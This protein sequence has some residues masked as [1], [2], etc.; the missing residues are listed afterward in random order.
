MFVFSS[1]IKLCSVI[2]FPLWLSQV[3]WSSST[4]AS[5]SN[6]E[7][8]SSPTHNCCFNV[9]WY[10][11]RCLNLNHFLLIMMLKS[12]DSFANISSLLNSNFLISHHPLE[13][14]SM[15]GKTSKVIMLSLKIINFKLTLFSCLGN[16]CINVFSVSC[17]KID[18]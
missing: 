10:I 18:Q 3:S 2:K 16:L 12:Y 8:I 11:E 9:P 15:N 17:T 4:P 7:L 5:N 13:I 1:W 14:D 6:S